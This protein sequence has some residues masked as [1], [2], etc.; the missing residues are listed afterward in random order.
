MN[1]QILPFVHRSVTYY[2]YQ[3]LEEGRWFGWPEGVVLWVLYT[4]R[5]PLE[6]QW[7]HC[8][9]EQAAGWECEWGRVGGREREREVMQIAVLHTLYVDDWLT[10]S[11]RTNFTM[12]GGNSFRSLSP[13]Y[14]ALRQPATCILWPWPM[15]FVVSSTHYTVLWQWIGWKVDI[16]AT[17]KRCGHISGSPSL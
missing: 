14:S 5:D 9:S 4:C 11:K 8:P 12:C 13:M 10:T 1:Q 2:T 3:S 16:L 7:F 6:S 15:H 17:G